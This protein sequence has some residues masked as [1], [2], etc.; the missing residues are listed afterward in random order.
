MTEDIKNKPDS[1]NRIQREE[2]QGGIAKV[3]FYALP[4]SLTESKY[5]VPDDKR[6]KDRLPN[7]QMQLTI[8]VGPSANGTSKVFYCSLTNQKIG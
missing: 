1:M 8:S 6:S 7:N 5:T 4:K 3:S 2:V